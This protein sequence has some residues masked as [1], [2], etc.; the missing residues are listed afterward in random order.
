MYA[1]EMR[2]PE[3][4]RRKSNEP[5]PKPCKC[6]KNS[7]ERTSNDVRALEFGTAWSYDGLGRVTNKSQTVNGV[8][9]SVG[10]AYTNGNLISLITPSGQTVSYGYN[11]NHQVTNIVV[12]GTTVLNGAATRPATPRL[13]A[14][15]MMQGAFRPILRE[16]LLRRSS[17]TRSANALRKPVAAEGP[18][19]ID[20]MRPGTCWG[21]IM[22][23]AT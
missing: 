23:P 15:T 8:T 12:N 3:H 13:Q 10:Y 20:T 21:N 9:A 22:V 16:D 17:I 1:N 6:R 2:V 14:A 4:R 5:T 18:F 7:T 11:A 19:Y